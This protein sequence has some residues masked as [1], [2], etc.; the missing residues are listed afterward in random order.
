MRPKKHATTGA[1]G[2]AHVDKGHR[3]AK[4]PRRIFI[5]GQQRGVF[6]TV[7]CELRRRSAIG[8]DD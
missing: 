3:D 6:G 2:R 5:S 7:K 8:P 4:H 1:S